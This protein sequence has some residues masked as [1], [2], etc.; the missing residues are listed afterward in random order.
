MP[1][2][3][4]AHDLAGEAVVLADEGGDEGGGGIVVDVAALGDLLDHAVAHH[5]DMVG[6]GER[7]ALIVGD[8]DEGDA[9]ALLDG[10]QLAAHMLAQ[11]EVE[12][13]ERLVEQK[14]LRLG[15]Q[16]AGDRDPLLLA[17]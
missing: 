13:G 17:A 10:A 16:R 14:H 2:A 8:I 12:R 15:A 4:G 6:H 9:D 11:L 3:C 5:R 1:S 7:L